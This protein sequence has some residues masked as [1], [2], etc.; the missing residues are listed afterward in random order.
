[1][2]DDDQLHRM[3]QFDREGLDAFK[4]RRMQRQ[5]GLAEVLE[6]M[7]GSCISNAREMN[8]HSSLRSHSI[9]QRG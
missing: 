2:P 8:Y 5:Q 9:D 7:H 6:F 1:M 3:A 4:R